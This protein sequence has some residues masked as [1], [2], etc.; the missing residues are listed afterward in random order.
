VKPGSGLAVFA[1]IVADCGARAALTTVSYDRARTLGSVSALLDRGHGTMAPASGGA[2]LTADKGPRRGRAGGL[3][4]SG[5]PGRSRL[6]AV[7]VGLH[8]QAEGEC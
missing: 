4:F 8:G 6:R 5:R 3:A 1:A 2:G 7:H